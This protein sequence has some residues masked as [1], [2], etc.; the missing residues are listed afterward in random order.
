MVRYQLERRGITDPTVL[1]AMRNVPRHLFVPEIYRDEAYEDGPLPI[2]NDQ[3]I[4]QPY[5]VGYMTQTLMVQSHHR[6]LEIG[7]GSGYQ[8]AILG[9]LGQQV[10]SVERQDV[11]AEKAR[12]N[13]KKLEMCNCQVFTGNG[14]QGLD[15]YA[16][17]D[18]ILVTAAPKTIPDALIDQLSRTGIMVI[19][20]GK[21]LFSQHIW[22]VHKNE[23]GKIKKT[24]TLGVRFVPM[25]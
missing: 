13:L 24:K 12:K 7:T 3:T 19:P 17:F 22:I 21:S 4:S 18:R 9:K 15:P 8:T 20:F 6:I 10:L 14:Y 25:V 2:G 5:I 1:E 16:P 23:N 11:L